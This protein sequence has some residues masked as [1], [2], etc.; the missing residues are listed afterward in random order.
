MH[1]THCPSLP[2]PT[3][4]SPVLPC[5]LALLAA[6]P[7]VRADSC[8]AYGTP[9]SVTRIEA[10][11]LSESSGIAGSEARPD[12]WFTHDDSGGKARLVAFRLDGTVAGT[13]EVEGAT[14]RDWEDLAAGPCPGGEDRCLY[15]AD[16]GDNERKYDDVRVYAVAVPQDQQPAPVLATWK[17][18]Y[19]QG[20][21]NAETLLVHPRTGQVHLVTKDPGGTSEVYALPADPG[22]AVQ[23][24]RYVTSVQIEGR[25]RSARKVTGGDWNR[26]GTRV[27]LR[28]YDHALEWRVP[29]GSSTIPWSDS[30]RE[31]ALASEKQGEAIT[32]DTDGSLLT[33]SEGDP[34]PVSRVPCAPGREP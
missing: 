24:L 7:P 1:T 21:R 18:H 3:G 2:C 20:P 33:T 31:V 5:L 26:T 34:M 15:V 17:L 12:T 28:T 25:N 29:A 10:A 9:V 27:V 19:P 11:D 6:A 22:D 32:Y 8:T 23:E 4:I 14:N 13:H 30:P 16:I